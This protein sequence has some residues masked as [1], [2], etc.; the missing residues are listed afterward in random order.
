LIPC[1]STFRIYSKF[2]ICH[3]RAID[4]FCFSSTEEWALAAHV[5]SKAVKPIILLSDLGHTNE[6]DHLLQ[7]PLY[8]WD[9]VATFHG[10]L[11]LA[12]DQM[13]PEQIFWSLGMEIV[14]ILM[15][16]F[17]S[18][19]RLCSE[20]RKATDASFLAAFVYTCTRMLLSEYLYCGHNLLPCR[21]R[22]ARSLMR[23]IEDTTMN[24]RNPGD[25]MPRLLSELNNAASAAKRAKGAKSRSKAMMLYEDTKFRRMVKPGDNALSLLAKVQERQL[26]VHHMDQMAQLQEW[27]KGEIREM[28]RL[29]MDPEHGQ[30]MMAHLQQE[31]AHL[32]G[33]LQLMET[34]GGCSAMYHQRA[35]L[36]DEE[37][38]DLTSEIRTLPPENPFALTVSRRSVYLETLRRRKLQLQAELQDHERKAQEEEQR[39]Q[40]RGLTWRKLRRNVQAFVIQYA[41]ALQDLQERVREDLQK[42]A[43]DK[44]QENVQQGIVAEDDTQQTLFGPAEQRKLMQM[45]QKIEQLQRQMQE[46]DTGLLDEPGRNAIALQVLQF[47]QRHLLDLQQLSSTSPFNQIS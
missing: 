31:A 40:S 9:G 18:H 13:G 1:A 41:A 38:N 16:N 27:G 47:Q 29:V 45:E 44:V 8:Q 19:T 23:T 20:G 11:L 15:G 35:A 37:L 3:R 6:P 32:L 26:Q 43:H 24:M 34:Q 10:L 7:I 36:R 5:I 25:S 21:Q 39:L 22:G 42:E 12:V 2:S 14:S 30:L 28:L 17:D 46:E 4:I 33:Q